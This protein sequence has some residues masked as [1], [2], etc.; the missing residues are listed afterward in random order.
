MR[1][2]VPLLLLLVAGCAQITTEP[3][4]TV[5]FEAGNYRSYAWRRPA[6]PVDGSGADSIY[7]LDPA[8]RAA[9][10]EALT[11][12]GYRRSAAEPD[13][14]VDYIVAP[15]LLEGA[16]SRSADNVAYRSAAIPN[17]NMDQASIDNAYAL[18]GVRETANIG[19][20]LFD[21]AA[22][23]PVWNVRISKIIED[24]NRVDVAL[25][26][27]AVLKGLRPLPAAPQ[28]P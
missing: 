27:R 14:L 25:A 10:D 19:I 5:R 18:G 9:V 15:G 4:D 11:A 21:A 7:R 1:A 12:K 28:A 24:R 16:V 20:M 13:F 26:R 6:L 2:L 8:I 17:R 22:E 3:A 23:E